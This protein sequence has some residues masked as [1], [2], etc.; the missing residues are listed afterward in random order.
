MQGT[1]GKL[2]SGLSMNYRHAEAVPEG[3]GEGWKCKHW[4]K[5]EKTKWDYLGNYRVSAASS[6]WEEKL[7][8]P[9]LRME[10]RSLELIN[11]TLWS[12]G[13]GG[14]ACST[15]QWGCVFCGQRC[16]C[17]RALQGAE[18]DMLTDHSKWRNPWMKQRPLQW[19]QTSPSSPDTGEFLMVFTGNQFLALH[20]FSVSKSLQ[21]MGRTEI[22]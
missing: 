15:L 21:G 11:C 22:Q 8:E 13:P 1:A 17:T 6:S 7:Y 16:W 18:N 10:R 14:L 9:R 5:F 3:M 12:Q 20:C 19:T 2:L 4:A